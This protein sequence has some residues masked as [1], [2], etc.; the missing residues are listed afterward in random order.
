MHGLYLLWWVQEK[1][2]PPALVAT[3]LAAGDFAV[4]ALELPTG[5]L[6]DR[7]GHRRS[8]IAGSCVQVIG[9]L[10]CWLGQGVSG[11]LTAS[12]LVAGGDA[13]RSGADQA[14]LYRSCAAVGCA[15]DF[16]RIQAR[17]EAVELCVLVLLTAGGGLVVTTWGF[18]AGW[19]AETALCAIGLAVAWAMVEPPPVARVADERTATGAWRALLSWRLLCLVTPAA[20]VGNAASVSSFLAQTAGG[21]NA[22]AV[23]ALV[24]AI[25]LAEAAGSAL[26][27]HGGAWGWRGHWALAAAAGALA[28]AGLALPVIL[29]PTAIALSLLAGITAPLRAT[30]IQQT[31]ADD[32]RARAAS[33]AHA[34]DMIV[35]TLV[36]PL[37]G[38]WA[39]RR[40]IR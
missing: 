20:L 25:T 22:T 18:A 11:L 5:W 19:V 2:L 16:Q 38:V 12:V 6:A 26:I 8:L 14:L 28:L 39:G 27:M 32:A 21:Y 35:S 33:L 31:V 17:T 15:D 4:M 10:W 36:L 34:C 23:G 37:A 24:G 7:F 3:M 29:V 30:A 9:M 1:Q 13:L 40:S